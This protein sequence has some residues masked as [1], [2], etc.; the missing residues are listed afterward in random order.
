MMRLRLGPWCFAAGLWPTVATLLFLPLLSGLGLW[1]L[2]RAGQKQRL[3]QHYDERLADPAVQIT[4]APIEA[5]AVQ[6]RR[7]MAR[8]QY[9]TE[10]EILLDNRVHQGRVGYHVLTPLRIT[11]S[12]R[13]VLVNR[14]WVAQG[15]DRSDRPATPA[16]AGEVEVQGVAV[17]PSMPGLKLGS[18]F[19]ESAAW[20]TVWQRV[21]LDAYAARA[22]TP[23]QPVIILLD[24]DSPAGGFVRQ[25]ARLDAGI[26]THH[27]YALTWFSLAGVLLVI[28][29]VLNTKRCENRSRD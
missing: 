27:G 7:V 20:P 28:Y 4:G 12:D 9:E 22:G 2:D 25:W 15:R 11:G 8:G 14:G 10:R 19:Q 23:V 21:E 16:P 5:R 17:L 26:A 6:F 1:Q 13:R 3:Q 18:G 29:I 24:A